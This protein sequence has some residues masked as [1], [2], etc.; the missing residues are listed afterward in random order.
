MKT[1]PKSTKEE[2]FRWIKPIL[3]KDATIKEMVKV[4]PFSERSL[5]YWLANYR[6][7][8]YDGL[9]NKSTR[10]KTNPNETPIRIKER[11]VELRKENNLCS[12]K[13]LWKLEKENIDVCKGVIDKVIKKEGLTRKY[14]TRKINYNYVRIPLKTGELVEIDVK[15]VPGRIQGERYYQFT[16]ID[17]ASRWRYLAI[18]EDMSNYSAISFLK[19]LIHI[20]EFKIQNIKTDNGSCF[21]NRYTGYRK[22]IDPM[23]PR[24]HDF[25]LECQ[26]N[27]IPHYL[28]DLGKP[29][30]NG[31][32]ER[33]H[34]SD[35]ETFYD[36]L[37][38][39][40]L[41]L[42]DLKYQIRLWNNHYNNL[43]HCSLNG[44]TPNNIIK[45]ECN[46]SMS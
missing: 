45:R 36:K 21:T 9:E 35:Q 27:S 39:K 30:Q 34:R 1:M 40:T 46:M 11:I 3:E 15:W 12:L 24:V 13:L 17:C 37:D 18:Y 4:C 6:K 8:G 16:A 19:E 38:F 31:K 25:D 2:K 28:I 5:K 10:P 29:Q 23:F 20:A 7:H 41:T 33:S 44:E 32:V 26:K 43:E 22:S 14:K 42:E